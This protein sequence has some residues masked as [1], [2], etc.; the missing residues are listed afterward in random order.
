[1][2]FRLAG[3]LVLLLF[4]AVAA[5]Q[6]RLLPALDTSSP[7]ATLQSLEA[8]THRLA[9][10][11]QAYR[12]DPTHANGLAVRDAVRRA[13]DQLLDLGDIPAATHRKAG[14]RAL[15]E[16]ADIMLRLP[17]V[18]GASI[19][20]APGVPGP[21]PT[22]WTVPGT[23]IR[24]ERVSDP[25]APPDYRIA[26]ASI[27]RLGEFHAQV[28][29][30]PALRPAEVTDWHEA[31]I[32]MAGPIF[33]PDAI[34]ALPAPL[35]RTV[36]ATPVWKVLASAV[37]ILAGL[38]GVL[39]WGLLVRRWARGAAPLRA[40][41]RWLT[42]PLAMAAVVAVAH[43][44]VDSEINLSGV[45]SDAETLGATVL[46]HVAGAWAAI[47]ACRLVAEAIIAS[48]RVPDTGY[49]AHLLRLLA[50]IGGLIAAVAVMAYGANAV[51]IPALGL[52]AGL[53]VGGV[54]VALASQSTVENLFGGVSIFA[55]RP[56]RVGDT[57][58]FQAANGIV[59]SIGPRSTRI[60]SPDGTLTTVPN[61]DIAKAHVTNLSVR[62][63]FLFDHRVTL[64]PGSGEPEVS[65]VLEAL[66]ALLADHPGISQGEGLSRVRLVALAPLAIEI[67]VHAQVVAADQDAFL[68]VQEAL[69]LGI[70]QQVRAA[71]PRPAA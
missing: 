44:M 12:A 27:A 51:G 67:Q 66:R 10:L 64:P 48:P 7:Y 35:R 39:A 47:L 36:L 31:Q 13:A 19:P 14:A 4:G 3:L 28:I 69:L 32:Q 61:A 34:A 25:G 21:L 9:A 42:V 2:R 29:G 43:V 52:V 40:A 63:R 70:L 5:A 16:L 37:V 17:E 53:G 24:I 59:E 65:R 49:D 60:R 56:F 22:R 18:P 20:G 23:E 45:L 30:Q 15:A 62:S 1:M 46:L 6:G 58:R 33:P 71:A 8:E 68:Q 57:I 50:R 55:D 54:A 38:V 11:F 26:R 41:A